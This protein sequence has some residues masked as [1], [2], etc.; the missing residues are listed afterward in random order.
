MRGLLLA[1][2][3]ASLCVGAAAFAGELADRSTL[4]PDGLSGAWGLVFDDEFNGNALDGT[5]WST[6]WFGSGI[7]GPLTP[8]GLECFDPARVSVHG[9]ALDVGMVIKA[10]SCAGKTRPFSSGIVTTRQ[11]F[12]FTYGYIEARAWLPGSAGVIFDWPDIWTDGHDW[13]TTGEAD[14]VEGLAGQAC[15]NFHSPTG[16]PGRCTHRSF[17]GGWH[18]FGA[19]WEPGV[20]SYYYDGRLVGTIRSGITS[21]PMY[22]IISMGADHHFGGP[23]HAAVLRID[24]VRIWQHG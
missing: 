3:I 4:A 24:Y 14:V 6:G 18:T 13:P 9:G 5:K 19:D 21:S 17:T 23:I 16:A 12:D 2:A 22:V 15:W 11:T 7:T 10:E 20:V 8:N 1:V